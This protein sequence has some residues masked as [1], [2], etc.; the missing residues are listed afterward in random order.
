MDFVALDFE[1]AN[2]KWESACSIGLA[3]VENGRVV[4]TSHHLIRPTEL[5]FNRI[6]IQIHGIRPEDVA[7]EPTLAELW[8][9]LWPRLSGRFLAAHNASFDTN[10]LKR[11]LFT[12]GLPIPSFD[13][14]CS[15]RVA[16]RAWPNEPNFKLNSLASRLGIP[17]QHHQA[18]SDARACAEIILR[19]AE[20]VRAESTPELLDR[21]G[22]SP[23]RVE[24]PP[25]WVPGMTTRTRTVRKKFRLDL[26]EN[27]DIKLHPLCSKRV[28]LVGRFDSFTQCE[29]AEFLTRCGAEAQRQPSS[30]TDIVVTGRPSSKRQDPVEVR[31]KIL[32]RTGGSLDGKCSVEMINEQEFVRRLR[33]KITAPL[34][35]EGSA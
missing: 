5:R 4:E 24:L 26:P 3:F 33:V 1:T 32:A 34:Q 29:A 20:T 16:R 28:F 17:L 12:H 19:A 21:L 31:S 10:V 6:N 8:P 9:T 13:Y 18:E 2:E 35:N 27:Y 23:S 30:S 14:L 11:A 25:D 15:V 7:H 22:I